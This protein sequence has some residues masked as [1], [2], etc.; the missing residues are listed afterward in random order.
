MTPVQRVRTVLRG[1]TPD[2]V[3]FTTYENK[4][5]PCQAERRLRNGGMCIVQRRPSIFKHISPNTTT[6]HCHY[7]EK[8][9][10]YIRTKIETPKGNLF[11]IQR[12]VEGTTWRQAHLFQRPE[13]YA[14]LAFYLGDRRPLPD[15]GPFAEA[16]TRVG[17][18]VYLR[19]GIDGYSPLMEIIIN[20]M[21]IEQFAI[22]WADRRDEVLRLYD[23]IAAR[24]RE[25]Y[26]IAAESPAE[27]I[28]YGGNVTSELVG[29]ERYERYIAPHYDECAELLHAHGKQLCVHFDGNTRLLSGEIGRSKIDCIE[30]FTPYDTDMTMADA[31]QAWPDKVL[32]INFPSSVHL[33]DDAVIARTTRRILEEARTRDRLLIGITEDVPPDRW[34]RSFATILKTLQ[35]NG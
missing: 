6:R 23:V 16:Q 17:G 30:A 10:A 5:Y 28:A 29:L 3:P 25:S 19:G 1:E 20:L 35:Q 4:I 31:R 33:T 21:G 2:R 32:W 11:S 13:D 12:P 8:G 9:V 34:Q 27:M 18:D 7:T 24:R 15:Y 26:T 22:E 14:P